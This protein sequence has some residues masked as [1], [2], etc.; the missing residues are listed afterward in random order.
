M[1]AAATTAS[2]AANTGPWWL[3]ATVIGAIVTGLVALMVLAV[4]GRRARQDRQR[5]LLAQVLA[6]VTAYMEFPYIVRRRRGDEPAAERAR[7]SDA[8]SDVQRRLRHNQAVLR[9]E[10]PRL[11]AHYEALVAETRRVAGAAIRAGW[12][13]DPITDD[14]QMHVTDVDLGEIVPFEDAYV[15]A[16]RDHLGVAP[17]WLHVAG[18][19]LRGLPRRTSSWL[20]SDPALA[21]AS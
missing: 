17:W 3:T 7:I 16:V 15:T 13:I 11:A 8:I 14:G 1:I 4:N 2:V 18:R 21:P 20:R 5:Q 6:D 10:A 12:D 19:W 9:V